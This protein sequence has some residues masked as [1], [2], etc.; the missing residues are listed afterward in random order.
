MR[1]APAHDKTI[2]LA[3]LSATAF[4]YTITPFNDPSIEI[5]ISGQGDFLLSNGGVYDDLSGFL[6]LLG[7]QGNRQ[8]K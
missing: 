1:S 2:T 3:Q 7:T 8:S 6:A 5:G 4:S